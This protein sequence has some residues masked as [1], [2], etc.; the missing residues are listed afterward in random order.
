MLELANTLT[1]GRSQMTR[2][3]LIAFSAGLFAIGVGSTAHAQWGGWGGGGT[4]AGSNAR[5]AG[6]MAAG[7]G[8]FNEQTAQARSINANTA[9]QFNEYIYQNQQRRNQQYYAQLAQRQQN[10]VT[11]LDTTYTRLHDHPEAADIH[12]GDALNVVLDELTDPGVYIQSVQAANQPM[13][14]MFVK[15]IPFQYA[16]GAITIS[17]DDLTAQ[18][19]PDVLLT[20]PRFESERQTIRGLATQIR[21]QESDGTPISPELLAQLRTAVTAVK[22]KL[23]SAY[24]VDSPDRITGDNWLKGLIGL[25]RMLQTPSLEPYLKELKDDQTTTL[26]QLLSFMHTFNLRFGATKT[27]IEQ[28]TYD[29]LYPMLVNLRNQMNAPARSPVTQPVGRPDPSKATA[30]FSQMQMGQAAPPPAPGQP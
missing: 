19:V 14:G 13:S 16:A 21:K 6:V 1:K 29:Q 9:M 3:F 8:S 23:D 11:T 25:T 4:V 5:G 18:G 26:G 15:S 7:A 27:P 30:Y 17:L 2:K 28:A 24:P 22:S 20:N 12:R 10:V